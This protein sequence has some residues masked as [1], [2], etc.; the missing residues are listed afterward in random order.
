MKVVVDGRVKYL[1]TF[2]N[3]ES[4]QVTLQG[5]DEA[6]LKILPKIQY[7]V[8]KENVRLFGYCIITCN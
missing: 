2:V 8:H 6:M 4:I 7:L 5:V 3:S 1:S